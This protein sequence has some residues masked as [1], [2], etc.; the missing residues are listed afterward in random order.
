[1][2]NNLQSVGEILDEMDGAERAS[3]APER[4]EPARL[5][6]SP[7][8][9]QPGIYFGMSDEEYHAIPALNASGIKQITASPMLF[10]SKTPWLSEIARQRKADDADDKYHQTIGK[11]YHARILEG[12]VAYA[13]RFAVELDPEEHRDCLVSTA[14]I[15]AAIREKGAKPI[16]QV[17]DGF[18]VGAAKKEDWIAQLIELDPD[19]RIFS[20]LKEKHREANAGKMFIGANDHARIEIAARMIERDPG[21]QDAFRNG[22][23]EVAL[24]WRCATTGVLMKA[25]VD[26]LKIDMMVDL[27]SIGNPREMSIEQAIRFAIGSY[28]YNFQPCLYGEGAKAVRELIRETD[29]DC[30]RAGNGPAPP[31]LRDWALRWASYKDDDDWLWV[32]QAKGDAPITR[33]VRF[34]V[35]GNVDEDTRHLIERAK[36]RFMQFSEVFGTEPWLDVAPIY[37]ISDEDIPRYATEI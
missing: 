25:K 16:T 9:P 2:N 14:E 11:A 35:S 32:F 10:W 8:S 15:K 1:M 26:Y 30:I 12:P 5:P 34:P 22:Y 6:N 4:F 13:S 17:K 20:H 31:D 3:V 33:G 18:F 7:V 23:P 28:K 24:I 21:L 19:A 29:G 27:K 37:T 36:T